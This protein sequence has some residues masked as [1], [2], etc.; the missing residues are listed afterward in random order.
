MHHPV[1][2]ADDGTCEIWAPTQAPMQAA[3][4]AADA[5]GVGR[6]KVKVHQ[7]FLGGGFG[8][9]SETDTVTEATYLSKLR[10]KPVRV[11]LSREDDMQTDFY[12]PA[13]VHRLRGAIKGGKVVGDVLQRVGQFVRPFH[14]RA[15]VAGGE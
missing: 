3:Y 13:S 2:P 6:S 1:L 4:A 14:D 8:R 9:R 11:Q 7:T 5:A 12:R 15:I 10:R